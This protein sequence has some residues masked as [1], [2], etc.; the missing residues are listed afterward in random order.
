M[1]TSTELSLD[2]LDRWKTKVKLTFV[3]EHVHLPVSSQIA[4]D[5]FYVIH[6]YKDKES[7]DEQKDNTRMPLQIRGMLILAC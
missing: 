5:S 2:L 7:V 1:N 6:H 4:N 3:G